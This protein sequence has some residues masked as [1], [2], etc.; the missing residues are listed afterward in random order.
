MNEAIKDTRIRPLREKLVEYYN[1][2]W[3]NE[4]RR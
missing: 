3:P 1:K 4:V 2:M